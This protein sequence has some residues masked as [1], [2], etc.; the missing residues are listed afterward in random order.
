MDIKQ[1]T[2]SRGGTTKSD[3]YFATRF[4][5]GLRVTIYFLADIG[6]ALP[7]GN[8]QTELKLFQICLLH[9]SNS[10]WKKRVLGKSKE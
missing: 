10:I 4:P 8:C 7:S 2:A 9:I 5:L 1:D 3:Y 6:A